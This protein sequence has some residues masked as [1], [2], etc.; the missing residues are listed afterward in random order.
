MK[1]VFNILRT[2]TIKKKI[3]NSVHLD[4]LKKIDNIL[5]YYNS[6]NIL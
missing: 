2:P 5:I 1:N 4:D 3:Y 6:Y